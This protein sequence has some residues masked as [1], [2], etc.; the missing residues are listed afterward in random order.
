[1]AEMGSP[2]HSQRVE[3]DPSLHSSC[4]LVKKNVQG[5]RRVTVSSQVKGSVIRHAFELG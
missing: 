2:E 4:E 5:A 3:D 1:M